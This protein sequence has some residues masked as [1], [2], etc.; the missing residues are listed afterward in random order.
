MFNIASASLIARGR[1][2]ELYAW[3]DGQALKLFYSWCPPEWIDREIMANSELATGYLRVPHLFGS[4]EVED[5]RGLIYERV[6]GLSMLRLLPRYPWRIVSFAHQ[7]ARLQVEIHKIK[8]NRLPEL[9]TGLQHTIEQVENLSVAQK[10]RIIERLEVL[11]GGDSLCHFDFH[12][13]QVL[14]TS[15]GPVVIDWM[16]AFRGSP[17]AD[18]AR[19]SIMLLFGRAPYMKRLQALI[20]ASGQ[21]VFYSEY[22]KQYLKLNPTVR[23]ADIRAW[24]L[25]VAAG[26]LRENIPGEENLLINF[27]NQELEK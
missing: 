7:F 25:P 3:G 19:T 13:D 21:K 23:L 6:E 9:S 17:A 12:P 24:M 14:M 10:K 2:A 18:V 26:R 1:T 27:I 4:V 20:L 15:N 16:T 8:T 5:R 11:P 22:R